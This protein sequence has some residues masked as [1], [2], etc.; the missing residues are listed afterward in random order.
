MIQ[1]SPAIAFS[2]QSSTF[3][4]IEEENLILQYMRKRI[5]QH[6]IRFFPANASILELNCG[7]GIDAVFFARQGMKVLATDV[8]SGMIKTLNSKIE[9]FDLKRSISTQQ[10][11]YTELPK[12]AEGPFDVVFSDFGGLNCISDLTPVVEGVKKNLKSG[13]IVTLVVMPK[14]CPW[15]ILL[16]LKGNFKVAFRRFK[17][18]GAES[19]LEGQ[20]FKTF[21]FSQAYIRKVFGE[22]FSLV[23]LEGLC[24]FVPPPYFEFFPKKLKKTFKILTR[25]ENAVRFMYPFNRAADHFIITLRRK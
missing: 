13:G 9:L 17:K 4:K 11:S 2:K 15:E 19:H 6:C 1:E 3:D 14:I 18:D 21:Y 5:H 22:E 25:V 8:A 16:A 23:K 7:T 24:S 12:F 20:Y 10:C